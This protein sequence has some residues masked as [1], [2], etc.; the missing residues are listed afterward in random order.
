MVKKAKL[1]QPLVMNHK[2]KTALLLLVSG[3]TGPSN[4]LQ[5][6]SAAF[7]ESDAIAQLQR[8]NTQIDVYRAL[9]QVHSDKAEWAQDTLPTQQL[10]QLLSDEQLNQS[11]ASHL[12]GQSE[13]GAQF[14]QR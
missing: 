10:V 13:G 12:A 2:V 6:L 3:L 7:T 1:S 14:K 5:Q 8:E 11:I 4:A 9:E